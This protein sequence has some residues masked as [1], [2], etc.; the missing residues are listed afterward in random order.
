MKKIKHLAIAYALIFNTSMT[1]VALVTSDHSINSTTLDFSN[2]LNIVNDNTNVIEISD[3]VTWSSN[4]SMAFVGD[5][6]YGLSDNG[7]W[8]YRQG[9]A[10]LNASSGSM[11]FNFESPSKFCRWFYDCSYNW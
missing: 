11:S 10:A 1:Y 5:D 6:G 3:F 9:Y 4:V 7:R 8:D 2:F